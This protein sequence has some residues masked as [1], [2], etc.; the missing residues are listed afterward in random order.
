MV[1][2]RIVSGLALVVVL[3]A[4]IFWLPTFL[5]ALTIAL[6]VGAGLAEFYQLTEIKGYQP[7][8]GWGI[9][10]GIIVTVSS[11]IMAAG[12]YMTDVD[13]IIS[14]MLFFIIFIVMIKY[15]F[16]KNGPSVIVNG[17]ITL[18]GILYVAFLFTFIIKLAFTPDA[19]AGRGTVMSLIL[20][21][22]SSD[23]G[24]YFFGSK[25]GRHKLIPRISAKKS[26]EGSVAGVL[27]AVVVSMILKLWFLT[28]LSLLAAGGLGVLLGVV[29]QAGDL[30]E[31]LLKRD[32]AVKD[33]G[34]HIP[35]M[36]GILDIL[37]SLLFAAPAMYI[38]LWIFKI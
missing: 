5:V 9:S 28:G 11:Y 35:G 29:G 27:C 15:A 24:A 31:S 4:V 38:Y 12:N 1:I 32:A 20:I 10:M 33:S 6:V 7:F 13:R 16:R 17:A 25:W 22:K 21:T 2:K 19:Y 14:I 37:D 23:V 30:T 36:G 34:R 3:T 18:L 26:I 8:K